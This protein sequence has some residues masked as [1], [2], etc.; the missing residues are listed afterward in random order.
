MAN[1]K[2]EILLLFEKTIKETKEES[3]QLEI[4][5]IKTHNSHSSKKIIWQIYRLWKIILI[6]I[7]IITVNKKYNNK[8]I[9]NNNKIMHK[10]MKK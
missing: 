5:W 6:K 7:I 9:N 3:S 2:K 1:I 8:I 4:S 10:V